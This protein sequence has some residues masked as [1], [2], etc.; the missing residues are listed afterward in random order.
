MSLVPPPV[1]MAT[2]KF[3]HILHILHYS[4]THFLMIFFEGQVH[5]Y[6]DMV[7]S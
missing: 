5:L 3:D 2:H 6:F 7:K 4:A 1:E